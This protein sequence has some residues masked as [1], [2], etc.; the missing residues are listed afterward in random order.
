VDHPVV[1]LPAGMTTLRR[2]AVRHGRSHDRV[3]HWSAEADFPGP[4]GELASRGRHGGGIGERYF[5]EAALDAWLAGRPELAP[6]QRIDPSAAGIDPDAR[7]T[8]GRFAGLIGKARGTVNQHRDRPGFPQPGAD[9]LYRA[10]NLLT[11]WNTRTGRRGKG[12]RGS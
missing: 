5:D 4:A 12:S 7:V 11:Y 9:G 2:W 3:R 10:G 6:P 1:G 8:L